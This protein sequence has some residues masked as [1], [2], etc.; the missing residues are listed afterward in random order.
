MIKKIMIMALLSVF[1]IFIFNQ[2]MQSEASF[3]EE[4]AA[5]TG[6]LWHVEEG[7][8]AYVYMRYTDGSTVIET[9]NFPAGVKEYLYEFDSYASNPDNNDYSKYIYWPDY[10]EN[11]L[12]FP[13]SS[14]T[15]EAI[16]T[17]PDPSIYNTFK[18]EIISNMTSEW[19]DSRG[20]PTFKEIATY[21]DVVNEV[22]VNLYDKSDLS[23]VHD[24]SYITLTVDDEKTLTT[25][26]LTEA[27]ADVCLSEMMG[28]FPEGT[29]LPEA[30]P[31]Y[32]DLSM[33]VRMYWEKSTTE[34]PI[35]PGTSEDPWSLLPL[36]AGS[37][38][39]PTGEWGSVSNLNVVGQQVSFDVTYNGATYPIEPFIVDGS[40][41]FTDES[42]DI[43]YY[44]EP[45]NGDRILYFNFGETLESAILTARNH[46]DVNE[47]KG[48][49]LWNLSRNQIKV[50]DV[51]RVYNYIPEADED[52]NVY[53]YFYM[54]D[55]PI[56]NLIS[57]SA[58]LAYRYWDDGF[59]PWAQPEPGSIQYK[60]V[61][62]VKGE[63]TSVNPTW[64]ED[65]YK[66]AYISSTTATAILT[67]SVISGV[68]PV[69]GWAIV[70]A[71]F[72]IGAGL[73]VS[74]A[75][76]WF[77]YDVQQIEHVIPGVALASEINT[78]IE[79]QNPNDTFTVD[80]DK[81]YKLHLATLQ[82]YDDVEVMNDLSNVTQVV[83]ETDG[84]IFVVNEDYIDD[85]WG[86]P[87]T[88]PPPNNPSTGDLEIILYIVGGAI[89]IYI[90]GNLNAS[91]NKLLL[92][93]ILGAAIYFLYELGLI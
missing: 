43:L 90:L 86:G 75:N 17:N 41:D 12:S 51:K 89:G 49:A 27:A 80:T 56:D 68:V 63:S 30:N 1:S 59:F 33:G 18:V 72:L 40:L 6:G 37:P 42:N 20:E 65:A 58:T 21:N 46:N 2:T 38:T 11:D 62:A 15:K 31:N 78:Y 84:E 45:E 9:G 91:K 44:T 10:R 71:G 53:S 87:G 35:D 48:E 22:K 82:D 32:L 25:R 36:T 79:S 7:N 3:S 69:Y 14:N 16:L 28:P 4:P 77:A 92:F 39:N 67:Y 26:Q 23:C 19:R 74:D 24:Y 61:A 73:Q 93:L 66:M 5:N 34:E 85:N 83:W 88:L 8:R 60:N 76:E 57:V 52:G 13:N 50:T 47:W 54:P 70:G 81:L 29:D 55:V 64:V